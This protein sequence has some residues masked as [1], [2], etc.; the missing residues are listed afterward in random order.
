MTNFNPNTDQKSPP[1]TTVVSNSIWALLS[2]II[3]NLLVSVFFVILARN[4]STSDFG[5][6]VIANTVYSLVL[7]FSS[8]GL[9]H[10]FIREIVNEPSKRSTLIHKF[11]KMQLFIGVL[12]MVVNFMTSFLLYEDSLV[13]SLALVFGINI[14]FDNVINA[15]KY[16]NLANENQKVT[17]MLLMVEAFLK[18]LIALIVLIYPISIFWLSTMLL[19]LRFFT[20]N[21]FLRIGSAGSIHIKEIFGTSLSW[22]EF[23]SIVLKNWPFVIISSLS[24]INWRIGNIFVSKTLSLEAVSDFEVSFKLLSLAYLLPVVVA[25]SLY[26]RMIKAYQDGSASLSAI[27]KSFNAIFIFYGVLAYSFVLTFSD[28]FI[29]LL[30]GVKFAATYQYCNEIFLV[31]LV[32]PSIFLQANVLLVLKLERKDMLINL[33]SVCVNVALCLIGLHLYKTLSVVNYAIFAAMIVFHLLQDL[34]MLKRKITDFYHLCFFYVFNLLIYF[35]FRYAEIWSFKYMAFVLCW[36]II[37]ILLIFNLK[38]IRQY[39]KFG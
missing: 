12:F 17:F 16:L 21:L 7:G 4:Y 13:R 33:V 5:N 35:Y 29:P 39:L 37:A 15:L 3:Q 14:I 25:T 11:F 38:K 23:R 18:F 27:Y 30:F 19:L 36:T 10:W 34:I 1:S 32:F 26:P 2:N 31:M 24:I 8:L 28:F 6:Y 9:G 22:D 20:L